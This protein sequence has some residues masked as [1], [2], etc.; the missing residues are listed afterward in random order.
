MKRELEVGLE[1]IGGV[2]TPLD[3]CAPRPAP[4]GLFIGYDDLEA[5]ERA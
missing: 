1:R 4:T 2:R 3:I 5:A